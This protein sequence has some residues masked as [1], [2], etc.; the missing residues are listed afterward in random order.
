MP[1]KYEEKISDLKESN[2]VNCYESY[3]EKDCEAYRFTF[4]DINNEKNF[5][6]TAFD[7]T[8][9]GARKRCS[10]YA[11]SLHETELSSEKAWNFLTSDKPNKFKKIGTHIAKGSLKKE[12]GK[13]SKTDEYFHFNF[14]EYEGV[15]LE[16]HFKVVKQLANQ[17]MLDSLKSK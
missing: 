1:Y 8:N 14:A 2:G 11:V 4:A 15:K 9:N 17:E 7:V 10:G 13:C 16:M 3:V 12:L 5:L 6:P